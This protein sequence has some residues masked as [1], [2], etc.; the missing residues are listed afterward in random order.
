[1][2]KSKHCDSEVTLG[3]ENYLFWNLQA[4]RLWLQRDWDYYVGI[5]ISSGQFC[6]YIHN[7]YQTFQKLKFW[8]LPNTL[9]EL[10]ISEG[11][12]SAGEEQGDGRVCAAPCRVGVDCQS[13]GR[14]W[15]SNGLWPS[16][17]LGSECL[18]GWFHLYQH[19][20]TLC[21]SVKLENSSEFSTN[22][23]ISNEFP[24]GW[25]SVSGTGRGCIDLARVE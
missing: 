19:Y 13:A 21:V 4:G 9:K 23:A 20:L 7:Y 1:M 22:Q 8:C 6:N 17:V 3:T 24:L 10:I 15:E 5:K 12:S 11:M 16:G 14:L 25:F 2:P 18:G